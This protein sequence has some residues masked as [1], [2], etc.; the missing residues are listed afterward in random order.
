MACILTLKSFVSTYPIK[1]FDWSLGHGTTTRQIQTELTK[2]DN[3][4]N[5]TCKDLKIARVFWHL[6]ALESAPN[7][8]LS[9]S[10]ARRRK[11][12]LQ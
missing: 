1:R 10:A 12:K 3:I 6:Q 9:F 2:T 8:A 7:S 5:G 4:P 11:V